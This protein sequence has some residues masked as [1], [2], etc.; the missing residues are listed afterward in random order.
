MLWE[1]CIPQ[2]YYNSV[3]RPENFEIL[4]STKTTFKD[5]KK[6]VQSYLQLSNTWSETI[7]FFTSYYSIYQY[8]YSLLF[9]KSYA[10]T[11][12]GKKNKIKF[13]MCFDR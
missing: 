12:M 3:K 9:P 10:N 13:F 2:G 11:A 6:I 7:R 8:V 4:N 5:V 1:E